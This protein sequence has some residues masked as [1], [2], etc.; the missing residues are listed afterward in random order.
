[1]LKPILWREEGNG[2][3]CCGYINNGGCLV[4]V[5]HNFTCL[6]KMYINNSST[7][8][9]RLVDW[10][11]ILTVFLLQTQN[12]PRLLAIC[13]VQVTITVGSW[14]FGEVLLNRGEFEIGTGGREISKQT[15]PIPFVLRCFCVCG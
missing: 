6:H 14:R 8:I 9:T 5:T 3:I 4:L 12:K 10:V 7:M 15:M 13:P 11:V 1:M 2:S